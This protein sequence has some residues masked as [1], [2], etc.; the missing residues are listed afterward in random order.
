MRSVF[1]D[2]A[3]YVALVNPRDHLHAA[4]V[5][6]A[7]GFQG[8][9]VTTEYV[10]VE[11]GNRLSRSGDKGVFVELI[12]RLQADPLVTVAPAQ[13]ALFRRGFELLSSRLDK[14]WSLTDC[15]SFVVM[16]DQGLREALTSDHHFEQ[17]GF[18]P[19]L[20]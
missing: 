5:R 13:P 4:A 10:L 6:E 17:A 7:R 3:F 18:V 20:K 1:A 16:Q 9:V 12:R 14:D 11:L 2:T 8:R 19:L 15:I